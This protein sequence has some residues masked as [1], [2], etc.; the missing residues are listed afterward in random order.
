MSF[1]QITSQIKSD[2][3]QGFHI[4]VIRSKITIISQVFSCSLANLQQIKHNTLVEQGTSGIN[5]IFP[6][7]AYCFPLYLVNYA[8]SERMLC[9]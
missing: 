1:K 3:E 8:V 6:K 9:F 2:S 5:K 7:P 4:N